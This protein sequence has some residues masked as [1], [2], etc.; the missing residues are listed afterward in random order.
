M[1]TSSALAPGAIADELA[2]LAERSGRKAAFLRAAF[3]RALADSSFDE[4]TILSRLKWLMDRR[5]DSGIALGDMLP[6]A[7]EGDIASHVVSPKGIVIDFIHARSGLSR[8]MLLA[9]Y[10][11]MRI[12]SYRKDRWEDY[13]KIDDLSEER[14]LQEMKWW[15]VDLKFPKYYFDTTPPE[16]IAAQIVTNRFYEIQGIDSAAYTGMKLSYTS[17]D[18][19]SIYW[20]HRDVAREVEREIEDTFSNGWFELAMYVHG[21]LRLFIV[22]KGDANTGTS[23]DAV[24]TPAFVKGNDR[25]ERY[26]SLWEKT[27]A[28]NAMVIERSSKSETGE[29]RLMIGMPALHTGRCISP[30]ARAIAR[31]GV[32]LTRM[33]ATRFSGKFP[34]IVISCYSSSAFP[35][36]IARNISDARLLR[37]NVFT[38]LVDA[39]ELTAPEAL[40][41]NA[42]SFFVHQFASANDSALALL[43]HRLAG[44]GELSEIITTIKRRMD[45]DRFGYNAIAD[46]FADRPDIIKE[47]FAIFASRLSPAGSG[48]AARLTAAFSEK[49]RAMTLSNM[50]ATVIDTALLFLTSIVR[51]NFFIPEKSALSFR[52]SSDFL[53]GLDFPARPF[54]IFFVVGQG[55]TGFHVRFTDIARGGIR[56]VRSANYDDY[57]K[58]ANNTFEECFNLAYTQNKKNK[59]IP[60]GGSKGIIL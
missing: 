42:A 37:E 50:E 53:D 4:R 33:Y 43:K 41:I 34:I 28:A 7:A 56:I 31:T 18:G 57:V 9:V 25:T 20:A 36:A 27:A 17:P 38:P 21:D 15:I 48:D 39:G 40:F 10:D 13:Y 3:D 60:E 59:D 6:N 55:F 14:M 22:E 24:M 12:G 49:R 58:N 46:A 47:L 51:T 35:E 1:K 2:S 19:T 45:K 52:L 26:R 32:A 30:V 44:D 23:F 11:A 8:D 5:G 29:Q 54:G 16:S